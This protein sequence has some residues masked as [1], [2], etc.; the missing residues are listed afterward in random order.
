[1]EVGVPV[2]FFTETA[3]GKKNTSSLKTGEIGEIFR[4]HWIQSE[5]GT[6]QNSE[7]VQLIA[8]T[9]AIC[10]HRDASFEFPKLLKFTGA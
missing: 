2:Y 10:K 4:L 8:K 9:R 5:T 7:D 1:V 3:R 6:V